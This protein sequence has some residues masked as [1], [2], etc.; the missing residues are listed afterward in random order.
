MS[1]SDDPATTAFVLVDPYNDFFARTGRAWPMT[2]DVARAND[3]VAKI[4]R[5]LRACRANGVH[6]A[7]APHHRYRAGSFA[8]RRHPSPSHLLV[9]HMRL[10]AAGGRGGRFHEAL[11][12]APGELIASEHDTSCGFAGT[13]LH[14]LLR[15]S[16]IEEVVLA[17]ALANTCVEATGR[18][19]ADLGYRVTFLTDAVTAMTP[20]DY[21]AAL[22]S[23]SSVGQS[24]TTQTFI[25]RLGAPLARDVTGRC[26]VIGL[27][28]IVDPALRT[29]VT[30]ALRGD[31]PAATQKTALLAL[32]ITEA[33]DRQTTRNIQRCMDA[34]RRAGALVHVAEP[35]TLSALADPALREALAQQDVERVVVVGT[36]TTTHVDATAR[37]AAE[38]DF[39]V[40]V[41]RDACGA[42][43][44]TDH[45]L[46]MQV[47]LP[48][49]CHLIVDT[50]ALVA[51]I[52]TT[53][54]TTVRP[55]ATR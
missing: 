47:T 52:G 33:P 27:S 51:L 21:R 11:R 36:A 7:Y 16:G 40:T 10:F 25:A 26:R 29:A 28:S 37:H 14:D 8:E 23:Y 4:S 2:R 5:V 53:P 32:D 17:G 43:S 46:T 49:V 30:L 1:A 48:R 24:C 55:Y 22:N 12:P 35:A 9:K 42:P 15:P 38:L 45:D 3:A 6:V 54:S 19:A 44:R 31:R 34:A 13:D 50:E 18:T 39:H 41:V 20:R